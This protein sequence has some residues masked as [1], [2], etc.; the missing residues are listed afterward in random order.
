MVPN[1]STDPVMSGVYNSFKV[2][3]IRV[4]IDDVA[5]TQQRRWGISS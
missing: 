4:P 2:E 3:Y 1:T 5:P